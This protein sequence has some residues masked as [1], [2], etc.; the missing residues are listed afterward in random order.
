M[1]KQRNYRS[2]TDKNTLK[3]EENI[4]SSQTEKVQF[5]HKQYK[6]LLQ[7]EGWVK[8][9]TAEKGKTKRLRKE[10]WN[11]RVLLVG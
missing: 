4:L 9:I 2:L 3:K 10:Y 11:K 7:A 8:L 5:T 6:E 1:V